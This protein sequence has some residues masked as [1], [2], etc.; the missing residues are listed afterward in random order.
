M[1]TVYAGGGK[2]AT[3]QVELEADRNQRTKA[4]EDKPGENPL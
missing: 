2:Q 3:T 1:N 4:Q